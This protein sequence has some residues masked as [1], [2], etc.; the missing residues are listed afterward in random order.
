MIDREWAIRFAK[1]WIESWNSHD[2]ER[3][4]SH[5]TDDF[6]MSSPLIVQLMNEPSGALKGRDAVRPYWRTGL[7]RT[8]ALKFELTDA[9]IG[10]NSITICYNNQAGVRVAE[11]LFF[12]EQGKAFRG[13]AHYSHD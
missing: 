8:P 11:V 4:L 3:I 10:A 5:Y 6:E 13:S 12:D 9:L 7:A 1:E 2:L